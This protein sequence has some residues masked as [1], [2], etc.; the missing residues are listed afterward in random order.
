M[1]STSSS[2][3]ISGDAAQ[4]EHAVDARDF[5]VVRRLNR[6]K[7]QV[8]DA[9]LVAGDGRASALAG[10]GSK[11]AAWAGSPGGLSGKK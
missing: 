5:G 11:A 9:L 10:G 2:I 4:N 3:T 6:V 7:Q 1:A 8:G